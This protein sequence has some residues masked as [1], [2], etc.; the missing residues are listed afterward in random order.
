M[1]KYLV[2]VLLCPL[3]CD[4]RFGLLFVFAFVATVGFAREE[5]VVLVKSLDE[6]NVDVDVDVEC[7]RFV[8]TLRGL[9][10]FDLRR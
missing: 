4:D 10:C 6:G 9:L 3:N 2:L 5:L 7:S 8:E 1:V